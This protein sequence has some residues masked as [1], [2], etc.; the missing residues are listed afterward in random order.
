MPRCP[1]F[2]QDEYVFWSLRTRG[3]AFTGGSW[4]LTRSFQTSLIQEA[5]NSEDSGPFCFVVSLPVCRQSG[6]PQSP[7]QAVIALSPCHGHGWSLTSCREAVSILVDHTL[8]T[9]C[10]HCSVGRVRTCQ[11]RRRRF[12]S[13]CP[14]HFGCARAI[15]LMRSRGDD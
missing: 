5:R 10:G 11:V 12:D 2:S 8:H 6:G 9:F 4:R 3:L 15:P 13:D 1:G 7:P 14:L